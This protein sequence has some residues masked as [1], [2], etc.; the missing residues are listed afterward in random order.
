[1]R[2]IMR[3]QLNLKSVR[4]KNIIVNKHIVEKITE[5]K[6]HNIIDVY[7]LSSRFYT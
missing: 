3:R 1:M 7:N 6:N 2:K 5:K 4:K